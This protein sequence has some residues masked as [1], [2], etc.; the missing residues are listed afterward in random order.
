VVLLRFLA[1]IWAV[2]GTEHG[3]ES[4]CRDC[5]LRSYGPL[6]HKGAHNTPFQA[7]SLLRR[8]VRGTAAVRATTQIGE[9][10]I[11]PDRETATG[12][13]VMLRQRPLYQRRVTP[14]TAIQKARAVRTPAYGVV[15]AEGLASCW[16]GPWATAQGLTDCPGKG[17]IKKSGQGI[18]QR[19]LPRNKSWRAA[20]P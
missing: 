5:G 9:K 19:L 17:E 18:N 12:S 11:N 6:A 2:A 4:R 20:C 15:D 8:D 16:K 10:T 13:R 1:V 7:R 14:N 3:R